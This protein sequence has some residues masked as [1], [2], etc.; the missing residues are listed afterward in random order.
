MLKRNIVVAKDPT[1]FRVLIHRLV[2]FA[3]FSDLHGIRFV[4]A[5]AQSFWAINLVRGEIILDPPYRLMLQIAP[6]PIWAL[7][8]VFISL[9]SWS[10]ILLCNFHSKIYVVTSA[11]VMLIWWII[12]SCLLWDFPDMLA[13]SSEEL[14]LACAASL[15]F[16]RATTTEHFAR[17]RATDA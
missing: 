11:A 17:R 9:S 10:S 6:E 12:F 8:F 2:K 13:S 7:I 16:V 14:A 4:L 15:V 3:K 1:D 5:L